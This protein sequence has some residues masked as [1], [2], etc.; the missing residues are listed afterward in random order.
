MSTTLQTCP[1]CE[2]VGK[3]PLSPELEQVVLLLSGGACY[4]YE[5]ERTFGIT[6]QASQKRLETLIRLGLVQRTRK[7]RCHLYSLTP[8]KTRKAK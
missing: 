4:V 8:R 6:V 3:V 5:I 2:G 7:G 1:R